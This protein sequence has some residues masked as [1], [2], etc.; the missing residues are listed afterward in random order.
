MFDDPQIPPH[1][2]KRIKPKYRK[3]GIEYYSAWF[4]H[5]SLWKWYDSEKRRDQAMDDLM[6]SRCSVL[7]DKYS[8]EE[9]FRKV[10]R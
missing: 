3:Y 8:F 1:K 2:K 6:K 4:K 7:N 9:Q 10:Q 5:W